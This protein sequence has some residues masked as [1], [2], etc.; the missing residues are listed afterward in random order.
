MKLT[1][2]VARLTYIIEFVADDAPYKELI[3][4]HAPFVVRK[5]NTDEVPVF[6]MR[7]GEGLV[8][9]TTTGLEEVGEFD[10]GNCIHRVARVKEGGY[11]MLIHNCNGELAACFECNSNFSECNVS[12][13]GT[14]SNQHF[15]LDNSIMIAFAFAT[16]YHDTLLMHS[17]VCVK[18]GKAFLFQG[19]SGT[20]KSTHCELWLKYIAG[21]ERINDDNPV[22]RVLNDETWVFGSPWSGKTPIYKN[23]GY[24]VGGFLRLHQA[25]Y[26][27][28]RKM[29]KLEGF[30]S[31]LSS[32][33]TM[34]WDKASYDSICTTVSKAA[35]ATG[36]YDMHCLPDKDAAVLSCTTMSS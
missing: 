4:S 27:K 7:V 10:C 36:C 12:L 11:R 30:A 16:S 9:S 20:G 15:G 17:S 23:V 24:P 13:H 31:I 29:A 6:V 33:S 22:V 25:P 28:I 18:D 35:T 26:N 2:C 3:P 8:E 19:K 32:C 1:F 14:V 21:T 5:P 34:I